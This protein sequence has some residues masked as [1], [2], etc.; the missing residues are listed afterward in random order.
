MEEKDRI[1]YTL[2]RMEEK[3]IA[4]NALLYSKQMNGELGFQKRRLRI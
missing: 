1:I 4:L 3:V 2:G